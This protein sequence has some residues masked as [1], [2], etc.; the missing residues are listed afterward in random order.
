MKAGEYVCETWTWMTTMDSHLVETEIVEL[1]RRYMGLCVRA[2]EKQL[3]ELSVK[4]NV[5]M[6]FLRSLRGLTHDQLEALAATSRCLVQ[7]AIDERS[8]AHAATIRSESTRALFLSS[9]KV[10]RNACV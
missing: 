5:G 1:N 6:P 10:V 4:L 8:L 2:D 7:P 3:A 9:T